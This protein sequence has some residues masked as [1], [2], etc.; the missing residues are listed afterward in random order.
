LRMQI[1]IQVRQSLLVK[2]LKLDLTVAHR[3]WPAIVPLTCVHY[4]R[5]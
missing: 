3:G 1:S 2:I 5:A 4:R